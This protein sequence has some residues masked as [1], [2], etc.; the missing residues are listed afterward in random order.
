MPTVED[1]QLG[2]YLKNRRAKL[3]PA[4]NPGIAAGRSRPAR[5]RERDVVHL[6]GTGPGRLAFGG[7]AGS[8]CARPDADE[9]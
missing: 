7:G 5:K 4:A 6:A 2:N 8:D 3:D 1:N 9:F